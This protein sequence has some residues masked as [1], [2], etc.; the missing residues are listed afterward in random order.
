METNTPI[1]QAI[2]KAE[3]MTQPVTETPTLPEKRQ[4]I[5]SSG[6]KRKTTGP[7]E[8]SCETQNIKALFTVPGPGSHKSSTLVV[9]LPDGKGT[10]SFNGQATKSLYTMLKPA[11]S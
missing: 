2:E 1:D 8:Y 6:K 5:A 9:S 10:L 11:Y 7:L 4:K 3:A